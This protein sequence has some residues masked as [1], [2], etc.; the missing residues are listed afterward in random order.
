MSTGVEELVVRFMVGG[1]VVSVFALIGSCLMPRI[2]AGLFGAAPS[3][4]LATIGPSVTAQG[5]NDAGFA[6][7]A[8]ARK[9][10]GTDAEGAVMGSLG[11]IVS[12][13]LVWRL[14]PVSSPVLVLVVTTA[15]WMGVSVAIGKIQ[16]SVRAGKAD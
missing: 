4:A 15:A 13:V 2:F 7:T 8:R 3:V 11:L 9:A 6:G 10:A 16:S 1:I 12:A 5:E 14:L